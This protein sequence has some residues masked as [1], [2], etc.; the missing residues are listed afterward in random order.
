MAQGRRDFLFGI[1]QGSHAFRRLAGVKTLYVGLHG[2]VPSTFPA[3]DTGFLMEQVRAWFGCFLREPDCR[4]VPARVLI[5]PE[6]FR[7]GEIPARTARPRTSTTAFALPGKATF[8]RGGKAVRRTKP[9]AKAIE[10]FGSPT[11]RATITASGGWSRL[12]AVLSART[13]EGKEIVVSAGGVPTTNGL[14]NVVIRLI[15]QA[16]FIPKGSRLTLTL[17]SS[18]LAQSTSNLLYL[19]LPMPATA[20]VRVADVALT[21]PG[22]RTPITR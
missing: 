16:T 13:P 17:G 4:I 3:P 1:D 19:D 9:L 7:G 10:V 22:L 18:S 11:V 14:K 2:H 8:A 12:V 21:L 5:A 6:N 20:R 15:D